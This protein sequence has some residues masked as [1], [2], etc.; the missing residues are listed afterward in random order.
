MLSTAP[1][2]GADL[3]R[4]IL[5]Q[6]KGITTSFVGQ[7]DPATIDAMWSE[8]DR[9]FD[10][11]TIDDDLH[12]FDANQSFYERSRSHVKSGGWFVVEDVMFYKIEAWSKYLDSNAIDVVIPKIP[13]E[14]NKQDNF[15][16]NFPIR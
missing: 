6:D 11:I 2:H 15:L 8:L 9:K 14:N 1:P 10:I 7:T 3:D 12:R 13:R 4:R 16:I 5:F